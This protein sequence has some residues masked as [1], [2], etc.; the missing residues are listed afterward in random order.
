M[1]E[2]K[3][4]LLGV[5]LAAAVIGG[6]LA[7]GGLPL[8][9]ESGDESSSGGP[10]HHHAHVQIFINEEPR[11]IPAGVG[12]TKGNNIDNEV[13]GINASPIHTH[14]NSGVLHIEHQE[15]VREKRALGY[16]FNEVLGKRFSSQCIMEWCNQGDKVVKMY[17]NG[18]RVYQ[19]DDYVLQDR[20]RIAVV[21]EESLG[22]RTSKP[23][24][25]T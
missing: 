5:I 9:D 20:D 17:V 3:G 13:S 15:P 2:G 25:L 23:S 6:G 14:D 19:F 22:E 10:I 24:H 21:Y 18:Q 7:N 16:F 11:V 12:I 8:S 4:I 1:T